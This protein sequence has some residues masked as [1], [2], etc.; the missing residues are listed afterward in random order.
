MR[1]KSCLIVL[2]VAALVVFG[3]GAE[4]G[5]DAGASGDSTPAWTFTVEGSPAGVDL[6]EVEAAGLGGLKRGPTY[7]ITGVGRASMLLITMNVGDEIETGDYAP[8][9]FSVQWDDSDYSCVGSSGIIVSVT[10]VDP[11]R[12][13]YAGK[14]NCYSSQAPAQ[15]KFEAS[16]SGV[17]NATM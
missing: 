3:C 4:L 8:T 17:F 2:I 6:P 16:A 5:A 9:M 13:T 11:L 1:S 14:V 15:D 12:G 10:S 7:Q